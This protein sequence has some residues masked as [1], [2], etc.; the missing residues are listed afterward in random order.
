MELGGAMMQF[1][2]PKYPDKQTINLA[3][4]ETDAISV[5]NQIIAFGV[6]IIC[7]GLFVKFA[8]IGRL[9]AVEQAKRTYL[10]TQQHIQ[11]LEERAKEYNEVKKLY[12]RLND[13]FL[14]ESEKKEIDR[15]EI[16]NLIEACVIERADI[17]RMSITGNEVTITIVDTTLGAVSEIVAALEKDDRTG[18]VTVFTAGTDSQK[19][20]AG[21]VSADIMV[22]LR[23]EVKD[24]E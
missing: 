8:V 21:T 18:Y 22:Q 15:M 14:S 6:F 2:K 9:E 16:I 24:N 11:T 4:K 13:T 20:Q 12:G 10:E 3:L 5:R 23:Q 19:Q 17:E 7:L 1:L